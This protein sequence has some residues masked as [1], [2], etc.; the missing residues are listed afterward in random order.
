MTQVKIIHR[1]WAGPREMP[2]EYQE[3]GEQWRT[4]NP[5]WSVLDWN[6]SVQGEFPELKPI[7]DSLYSRDAGRKGI[8][9]YVQLADVIGY[10]LVQRYGGVYV[11]VDMQP[12]RALPEDLPLAWASYENDI[13][14]IV[15]AAIGARL[16]GDPFWTDLLAGLPARYFANPTA[17]M[18]AT[19][20]PGYLTDFARA[21]L[22]A[23]FVYPVEAFN[24]VHWKRIPSGG[25]AA[26]VVHWENE[27]E[28]PEG[29]IALHHWGHKK[30]N[31]VGKMRSNCVETATQ[32]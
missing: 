18:V 21:R 12:V 8:E 28:I 30:M 3:F 11:N 22:G 9:L 20:G 17:E 15:N 19:T 13:G 5:E 1:F 14:D 4:L 31:S 27:S 29:V 32:G 23:L 26:D 24:F 6:E 2:E 10:A 7:F 16:P 25:S